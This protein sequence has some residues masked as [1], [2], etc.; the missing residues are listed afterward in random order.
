MIQEK[1]KETPPT[2]PMRKGREAVSAD[3]TGTCRGGDG[4]RT[5]G[6]VARGL[7]SKGHIIFFLKKSVKSDLDSKAAVL[8]RD[9]RHG[10]W[11]ALPLGHVRHDC[12]LCHRAT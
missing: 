1:E 3:C 5:A 10:L 9:M 6:A 7:G 11:S 8:A 4:P 2:D 12:C